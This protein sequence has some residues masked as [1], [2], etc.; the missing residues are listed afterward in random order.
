MTYPS[1]STFP[2]EMRGI[3]G[4]VYIPYETET[5]HYCQSS[6]STHYIPPDMNV[7]IFLSVRWEIKHQE[8]Y[9]SF[10]WQNQEAGRRW[11]AKVTCPKSIV[12]CQREQDMEVM[13]RALGNVHTY[14]SCY[15][16]N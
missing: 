13:W 14:Q 3:L 12:Q 9:E 11:E 10:H 15:M 8:M 6:G 2:I 7:T 4:T 1:N 5:K 16:K